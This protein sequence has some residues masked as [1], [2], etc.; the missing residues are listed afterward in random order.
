MKKAYKKPQIY[1]E[2]FQLSASIAATCSLIINVNG[3]TCP[4][5][6][7]DLGITYYAN[8]DIC[9]PYTPG[10]GDSK[11]CYDTNAVDDNQV[12]SSI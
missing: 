10:P 1:F 2:S 11:I 6:D 3:N 7:P 5:T 8:T 12:F 9:G 4:V